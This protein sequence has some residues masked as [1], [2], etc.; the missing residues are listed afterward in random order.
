MPRTTQEK[1][2]RLLWTVTFILLATFVLSAILQFVLMEHYKQIVL[3]SMDDFSARALGK[4]SLIKAVLAGLGPSD[5]LVIAGLCLAAAALLALQLK[6]RA[7]S[8]FLSFVLANPLR[9]TL[10]ILFVSLLFL[11]PILIPGEPYLIDAPSHV[12]RAY[13]TF[14]NFSQ[15]YLFPSFNNYYHNGFAMF[16]HYGFLY[17]VCAG[18]L[19]LFVGDINLSVKLVTFGLGVL[20]AFLF[21][22]LG[23]G[24]GKSAAAG[25]LLSTIV[26]ASTLILHSILYSG[27]LFFPL[28]FTGAAILLLAYEGLVD[29]GW[30]LYPA[31]FLCAIGTL[32]LASTHLG[33]AAQVFLW[34]AI[35]VAARSLL[36]FRRNLGRILAWVGISAVLAL[37]FCA[38]VYLP[39]I[40]DIRDVNFYKAFPFGNLNTY[41]FW[42]VP[43]WQMF[44]PQLLYSNNLSYMGLALL[45][46]AIVGMVRAAR[47]RDRWFWL[48]IVLIG[49]CVL[50]QGY[51][52]N[53]VLTFL[54]LA[55]FAPRA[56]DY[57]GMGK[58]GR[59]IS[60]AT[61]GFG[62]L[63]LLL[64]LDGLICNNINTYNNGNG[65]E[66]RMLDRLAKAPGGEEFGVVKANTLHS[67]NRPDN[68][69]FVS[70]WLKVT[71]HL[72]LQPN[73]LML[74]ANKQAIYQYGISSDLLV[75]DVRRGRLG[76][77]TLKALDLIGVKFLTFHTAFEYFIPDL[78][79][80]SHVVRNE[81]GPWLELV[82]TRAL[83]FSERVTSFDELEAS[84]AVLQERNRFESDNVSHNRAPFK[85]RA[86]A[87]E[88]LSRLTSRIGPDLDTG[89]ASQ[90][91]LRSGPSDYRP[92]AGTP[93]VD[94]R[95]YSVD[96]Q[97]VDMEF[98]VD[99]PGFVRVP[100]A[101]FP[102]H[103]VTLN[104]AK[105]KFY[106][107]IMNMIVVPIDAPGVYSLRIGPSLSPAK[108]AG[109][110]T[111]V[112]G[113]LLGAIAALIAAKAGPR[114]EPRASSSK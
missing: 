81:A 85:Y 93:S 68:D 56:I 110:A 59:S 42:K 104:G 46:L 58:G 62:L 72:V 69:V 63:F 39:S 34:F 49:F 35:W 1:N 113:L 13:F 71:G 95:R 84:D 88:Y 75:S 80:E 91:I 57:I 30:K 52:R 111:S 9:T 102:W 22:N 47:A 82:G 10:F 76:E 100:F 73:A 70:P 38:F 107:D 86:Y 32:I 66:H 41:R 23:K 12:S 89:T 15:G 36:F 94:L 87:G 112:A 65:F 17:Y 101:Y 90:F 53:S 64:C 96:A 99:R 60:A 54:S 37:I 18:A 27:I 4:K 77:T 19:N 114:R 40:L 21:F 67:G 6:R 5:Y 8:G 97:K 24:L 78:E 7:L 105:T 51:E 44:V 20:N 28:V 45:G 25:L 92:S 106:P 26:S 48:E 50:V 79:R 55:L 33:Y 109:A 16:S 61:P 43:F 3:G 11:K 29:R 98:A 74:E 14:V 2:S 83:L 31:A 108:K 103:H